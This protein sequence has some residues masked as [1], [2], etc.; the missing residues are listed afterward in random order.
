MPG[1]ASKPRCRWASDELSAA[2]HDEE[3]GVPVHDD[4]LLFEMLILEGAQLL[5][6]STAISCIQQIRWSQEAANMIGSILY[7][8]AGVLPLRPT[9]VRMSGNAFPL[10]LHCE[11]RIVRL[12]WVWTKDD[13]SKSAWLNCTVTR[14]LL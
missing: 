5:R 12:S 7:R 2:Y 11:Y 3:W 13:G 1:L 6:V 8:H 10:I 9:R 4:R 14:N